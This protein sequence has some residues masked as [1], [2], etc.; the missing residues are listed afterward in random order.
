MYGMFLCLIKTYTNSNITHV[1]MVL[2]DSDFI[3]PSLK[4]YYVWE[5]N[6]GRRTRSTRWKN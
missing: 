3:D 4:G 5:S 1:A 2:K 6:R